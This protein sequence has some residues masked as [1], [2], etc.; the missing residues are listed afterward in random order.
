L[1]FWRARLLEAERGRRGGNGASFVDG[2]VGCV[3]GG[4]D[5]NTTLIG[6]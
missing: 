2:D 1:W 3:H 4:A 5:T 6:V